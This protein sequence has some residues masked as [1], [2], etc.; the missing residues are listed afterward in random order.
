MLYIESKGTEVKFLLCSQTWP[1][2][3]NL[4]LNVEVTRGRTDGDGVLPV[5]QRLRY[6]ENIDE[7]PVLP[8]LVV[9]MR[10]SRGLQYES[11]APSVSADGTV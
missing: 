5:V 6:G 11:S 4:N 8:V 9:L 10:A 3:L 2:K 1:I 7:G